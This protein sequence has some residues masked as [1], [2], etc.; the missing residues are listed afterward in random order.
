MEVKANGNKMKA[1]RVTLTSAA[2]GDLRLLLPR[3]DARTETRRQLEK[4]QWWSPDQCVAF[5]L[6]VAPVAGS[7]LYAVEVS[8]RF[9]LECGIG[10]II[11]RDALIP[12][13]GHIW[14]LVVCRETEL[15]LPTTMEIANSR[16][17]IL[18]QDADEYSVFFFD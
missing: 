2:D 16:K 17:L 12:P 9:G 18:D 15:S 10:M 14:I 11:W 13:N 1:G 6:V 7:D 8:D 3:E 4:L 5:D